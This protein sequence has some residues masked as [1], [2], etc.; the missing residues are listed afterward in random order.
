MKRFS[1]SSS[2]FYFK[3]VIGFIVLQFG[4]TLKEDEGPKI[5]QPL[6]VVADDN[7]SIQSI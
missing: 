6:S 7:R 1:S 2:S 5:R 4:H 3:V